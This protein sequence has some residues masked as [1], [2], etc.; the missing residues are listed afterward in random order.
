MCMIGSLP[1]HGTFFD[2]VVPS[3]KEL[4]QTDQQGK[5]F[6]PK[7]CAYLFSA[8]H[9]LSNG[10]SKEV[11][12]CDWVNFWFKGP[13][14]YKEPSPQHPKQQAKPKSNH[15]PN[16][17]I[18]MSFLPRTEEKNILF[19]VLGVEGIFKIASLMAYGERFALAIPVLTSIYRGLTE[20]TTLINS[21]VGD[22]IFP[23]K[24]V[25]GW[26]GTYFNSYY[27]ARHYNGARMCRIARERMARN[28][29]LSSG[30]RLFQNVDICSLL[31]LAMLQPKELF[32]AD[33]GELSSSWNDYFISLHSS[34]VTL[35]CD[36][37]F[38]MEPY[39]PHIFSR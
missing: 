15:S 17:Y 11:S 14:W 31:T 23:I 9:R 27:Q 25:Y 7:T 28:F 1:V 30:R 20:I 6:L 10:V 19:V 13:E 36:D 21:S 29:D 4:S 37:H 35:R 2:E 3:T 16:G 34:Y 22:I 12:V 32:I 39:S 8:F 38:I 24:C 18:D 26:I 33:N 5:P